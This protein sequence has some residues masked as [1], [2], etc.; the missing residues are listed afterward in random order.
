MEAK[1]ETPPFERLGTRVG[2]TWLSLNVPTVAT[3]TQ[4]KSPPPMSVAILHN[5]VNHM[6]TLSFFAG[7]SRLSGVCYDVIRVY[8]Q[9]LAPARRREHV[10]DRLCA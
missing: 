4:Y 10:S 3:S 2:D 8:E 9:G 1:S 6:V 7:T 5:R